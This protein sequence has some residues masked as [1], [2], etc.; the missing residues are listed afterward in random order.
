MVIR[1]G[2]KKMYLLYIRETNNQKLLENWLKLF[3]DIFSEFCSIDLVVREVNQ[4]SNKNLKN[5]GLDHWLYKNN[6]KC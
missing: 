5:K 1:I 4:I 3:T 2:K 6:T